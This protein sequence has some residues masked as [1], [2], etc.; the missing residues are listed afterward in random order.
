MTSVH[1]EYGVTAYHS[2]DEKS[3]AF[4]KEGKS[5]TI[6]IGGYHSEGLID[7]MC[8]AV[9]GEAGNTEKEYPISAVRVTSCSV[10]IAPSHGRSGVNSDRTVREAP[11]KEGPNPNYGMGY[12]AGHP[13]N[14]Y[15]GLTNP[16]RKEGE[17]LVLVPEENTA[18][19][20]EL[21]THTEGLYGTCPEN[22]SSARKIAKNEHG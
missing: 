13:P 3:N 4:P 5:P 7:T 10:N 12:G 14:T 18:T 11:R 6:D 22:E 8:M 9:S 19:I 2:V 21:G 15:E 17:R 1:G 16:C 20:D